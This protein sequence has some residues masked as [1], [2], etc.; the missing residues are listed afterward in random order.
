MN[1]ADEIPMPNDILL[2]HEV[3]ELLRC[4]VSS[5]HRFTRVDALPYR[6]LGREKRFVREEVRAW[7]DAKRIV[8]RPAAPAPA[9]ASPSRRRPAQPVIGSGLIK[10]GTI[11]TSKFVREMMGLLDGGGKKR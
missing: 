2:V 9:P 5:V 3:A 11:P 7:L 10:P 1:V 4:S 6:Q 8:H